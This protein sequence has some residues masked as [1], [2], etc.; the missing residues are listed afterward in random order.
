MTDTGFHTPSKGP[1]GAL[2][3]RLQAAE[4]VQEAEQTA[5]D[6]AAS[7]VSPE[8]ANWKRTKVA[9]PAVA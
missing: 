9:E 1:Y 3:A 6:A 2:A 5:M 4:L 7:A 8:K